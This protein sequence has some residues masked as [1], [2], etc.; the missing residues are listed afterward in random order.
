MTSLLN[1]LRITSSTD[2]STSNAQK[3]NQHQTF[4]LLE[5]HKVLFLDRFCSLYTQLIWKRLQLLTIWGFI[6]MSTTLNY[7]GIAHL[8][9]QWTCKK[10]CQSVMMKLQ[11]GWKPTK[12]NS[13]VKKLKSFGS[14]HIEAYANCQLNQ[15]VC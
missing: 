1:G 6:N 15:F 13:T 9:H 5:Y 7:M 2:H 4:T 12:W 10:E 11:F 14:Q 3:Q 8:M